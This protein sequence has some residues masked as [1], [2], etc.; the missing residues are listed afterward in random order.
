MY[1]TMSCQEVAIKQSI[2][3]WLF[4][5]MTCESFLCDIIIQ[6]FYELDKTCIVC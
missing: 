2:G 1:H 4:N 3:K 5:K 6:I